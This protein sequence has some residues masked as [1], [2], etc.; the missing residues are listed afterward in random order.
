MKTAP[1]RYRSVLTSYADKNCQAQKQK[2]GRLNW[3]GRAFYPLFVNQ[4]RL[5]GC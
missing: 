3:I 5:V 1:G 2:R 4:L